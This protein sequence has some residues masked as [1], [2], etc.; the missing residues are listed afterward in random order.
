M[1]SHSYLPIS[2]VAFILVGLSWR[3]LTH[4][5]RLAC[6]FLFLNVA[7]L[8]G[9]MH[10][11][12]SEVRRRWSVFMTSADLKPHLPSKTTPHRADEGYRRPLVP[13]LLPTREEPATIAP[14]AQD[15]H[16]PQ[17]VWTILLHCC[18]CQASKLH[19]CWVTESFPSF[20][21][22]ITFLP[23]TTALEYNHLLELDCAKCEEQYRSNKTQCVQG[24]KNQHKPQTSILECILVE[25]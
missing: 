17:P 16:P 11:A 3:A 24:D 4:L 5:T 19:C 8:A 10:L 25:N 18:A 22:R 12:F 15:T 6:A 14:T 13:F 1:P 21:Q 2:S 7:F 9:L 20:L 23:Q